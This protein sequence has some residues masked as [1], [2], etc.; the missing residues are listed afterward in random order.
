MLHDVVDIFFAH[1][2]LLIRNRE[3]RSDG[4]KRTRSEFLYVR[5]GSVTSTAGLSYTCTCGTASSH[6]GRTETNDSHV[7]QTFVVVCID[8]VGFF[9][10]GDS[11]ELLFPGAFLAERL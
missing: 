10:F 1:R 6:S 9:D 5:R 7:D 3:Q 8:F 2:R 11:L 4:G